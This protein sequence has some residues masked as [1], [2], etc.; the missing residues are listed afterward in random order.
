MKSIDEVFDSKSGW[1]V[2][3]EGTECT[4]SLDCINFSIKDRDKK[5]FGFIG[6]CGDNET[7]F[8]MT[9]DDVM[10]LNDAYSTNENFDF[11]YDV[12][13]GDTHY[14]Y[15]TDTIYLRVW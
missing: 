1:L 12:E 3:I 2:G 9:F 6:W 7:G 10:D 13:V 8:M 15:K 11:L 4:P 5:E 14:D